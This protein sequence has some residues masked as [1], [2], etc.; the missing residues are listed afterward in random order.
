MLVSRGKF[1]SNGKNKEQLILILLRALEDKNVTVVKGNKDA[2]TLLVK[3]IFTQLQTCDSTRTVTVFGNDTDIMFML[4]YHCHDFDQL[5]FK[6]IQ[7]AKVW[8]S[9]SED[10][11]KYFL[12]A[13]MFSGCDTVSSIFGRGKVTILKCMMSKKNQNHMRPIVNT[14]MNHQSVLQDIDSAETKLMSLVYGD[15]TASLGDL[16]YSAYKRQVIQ[17]KLKPE[18]LPPS[19][20]AVVQHSRRTFTQLREWILLDPN[21]SDMHGWELKNHGYHVIYT[22]NEI[23]PAELLNLVFCKCSG[24]CTTNKCNCFRNN[25]KC[26]PAICEQCPEATSCNNLKFTGIEDEIES[27]DDVG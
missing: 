9:M 14:F 12:L 13:Y 15:P 20:G 1:V 23:A 3:T 26:V 6:G 7:V 25:V 17:G 27:D 11:H 8:S 18:R 16:R 22:T 19:T 4:M 5:W 24:Q 2:D 10:E 21:L